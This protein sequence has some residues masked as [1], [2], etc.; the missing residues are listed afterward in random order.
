MVLTGPTGSTTR[1][2]DPPNVASASESLVEAVKHTRLRAGTRLALLSDMLRQML[3]GGLLAALVACAGVTTTE[4]VDDGAS[5]L[6]SS[7]K[8]LSGVYAAPPAE[9]ETGVIF[10][11]RLHGDDG[12]FTLAAIGRIECGKPGYSCGKEERPRWGG[13]VD[14]TRISGRW[15]AAPDGK[16]TLKPAA[17]GRS[18]PSMILHVVKSGGGKTLHVDEEANGINGLLDALSL[19]GAPHSTTIDD[20]EGTWEVVSEVKRYDSSE[21]AQTIRSLVGY[22]ALASEGSHV[23]KFT[24]SG[25]RETIGGT[26]RTGEA[27]AAGGAPSNAQDASPG[28]L[29][30]SS[31]DGSWSVVRIES[32]SDQKLKLRIVNPLDSSDETWW[33]LERTP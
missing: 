32:V 11:L 24:Q 14:V 25:V 22:D 20:L 33:Q 16:V 6:S 23:V 8:A 13:S 17:S 2:D 10:E 30:F 5:E 9:A 3:I 29:Y 18:G 28:V 1:T 21:H 12:T 4:R 27:R 19:D 7:A 31:H 26:T 15:D